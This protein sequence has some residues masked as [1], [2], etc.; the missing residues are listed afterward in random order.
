MYDKLI[1]L[2]YYFKMDMPKMFVSL[3]PPVYGMRPSPPPSEVGGKCGRLPS[4]KELLLPKPVLRRDSTGSCLSEPQRLYLGDFP[5]I[6][7]N[8]DSV[9]RE[10]LPLE[11]G[12]VKRER[13]KTSDFQLVA[14]HDEFAT[15]PIPNRHERIKLSQKINMSPRAIQVW[16]Q[17]K[18]QQLKNTKPT[19]EHCSEQA[20]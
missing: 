19:I 17:N 1:N 10:S 4:I 7:R 14:L 11:G 12:V 8:S 3:A 6:R 2:V 15:N 13:R 20:W 18:R 5:G 16:F 9:V